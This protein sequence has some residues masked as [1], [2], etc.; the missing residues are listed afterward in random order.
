M[1]GF[2]RVYE[3]RRRPG[4][5]KRGGYLLADVA[6]FT[7]AGD[8]DAAADGRQPAHGFLEGL[9]EIAAKLRRKQG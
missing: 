5:G 1:R 7:D 6:A 8:D 9:R 3:K 2:A 4:R